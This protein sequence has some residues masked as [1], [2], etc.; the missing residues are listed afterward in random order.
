MKLAQ[1]IITTSRIKGFCKKR[2]V[3]IPKKL[4][5]TKEFTTQS[6]PILIRIIGKSLTH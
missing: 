4:N 6:I 2:L 1:F 5:Q 3:Y